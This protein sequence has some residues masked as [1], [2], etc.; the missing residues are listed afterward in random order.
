MFGLG[1]S[2]YRSQLEAQASGRLEGRAAAG[3]TRHLG[4]CDACRRTVE[5]FARMRSLVRSAAAVPGPSDWTGFWP[6]VRA[7]IQTEAPRPLRDSWWLPFWKPIWGHPRLATS[8]A[9]A[10]ALLVVFS[11]QPVGNDGSAMPVAVHDVAASDPRGSVMVYSS[12]DATVI[13]MFAADTSG[14]ASD[15]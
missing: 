7:R 10:A 2:W 6:A 8:A 1:C 15:E 4:R 3:V 13:W 14:G 12:Q 11:L 9:M 5:A